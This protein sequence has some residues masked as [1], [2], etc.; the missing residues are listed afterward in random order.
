M[1]LCKIEFKRTHTF[2]R[3][4]A[5]AVLE[6]ANM[7]ICEIMFSVPIKNK[8]FFLSTMLEESL[9]SFHSLSYEEAIKKCTVKEKVL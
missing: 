2:P 3:H 8:R 9:N 5:V 1:E 4:P 6:T 7:Y